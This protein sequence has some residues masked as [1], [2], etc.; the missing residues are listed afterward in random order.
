MTDVSSRPT[1]DDVTVV[2]LRS[3]HVD[4]C[5]AI[6]RSLPAWFGIEAGLVALRAELERGEGLVALRDGDVVGF[7]TL[8]RRFPETWEITWMAVSPAMHRR[9]IGALLV[10]RAV[11]SSRAAGAGLLLVQ[12]LADL[13]PSPEY[14]RTRAF[15]RATGFLRIAVLPEEWDAENPCLLLGRPL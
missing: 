4:G 10:D 5:E 1:A 12:T 13:H 15:Y 14:A 8:Q 6:A 11:E 2:A 7:I 3:D 9:G